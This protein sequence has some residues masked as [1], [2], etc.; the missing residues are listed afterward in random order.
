MRD[1]AY[2]PHAD[3]ATRAA[4]GSTAEAGKLGGRPAKPK[5]FDVWREQIEEDFDAWKRPYEEALRAKRDDGTPDHAIRMRASD[6][7]LDAYTASRPF[8]PG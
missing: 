2:L 4:L 1:H 7:V 3:Q 6:A 8:G 5:P